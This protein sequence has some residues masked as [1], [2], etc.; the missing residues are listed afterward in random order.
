MYIVFTK[1]GERKPNVAKWTSPS[2]FCE[3]HGVISAA[4]A[5]K[6]KAAWGRYK[7]QYLY[8]CPKCAS[9]VEPGWLPAESVIDFSNKGERIGDKKKPLSAKTERRGRG[10]IEKFWRPIV[11]E[12]AGNTYDSADPKHPQHGDQNGYLRAWP[13]DDPLRTLHATASK[14]M[15]VPPLIT[16]RIHGVDQVTSS[17]DPMFTQTTAQTKSVLF[18]PILIPVEGR[19]G[20][21]A[22]SS[23]EPLRTQTTRHQDAIIIPF[24][25]NNVAKPVSEPLDTVRA[26]GNHHGLLVPA[27][28]TWRDEATS[29]AEP[30]P[31]RTTVETDALLVPYYGNGT[32][33][34]TSEAHRTLTTTD[35][36]ALL[37][38][39]EMSIEWEDCFFR[40]L[41]PDE[42]KQGMAFAADYLILGNK[43]EQVKQAGNAVTPPAARDLGM[44]VAEA[45]NGVELTRAT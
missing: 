24:T 26:G 41:T 9:I 38:A 33:A 8:R 4:Q 17:A 43:R 44:A 30:M 25:T 3:T 23:S 35:R 39:G 32:A 27:G 40:M 19:E 20:K 42:I 34:P 13:I 15:V 10:G 14:A 16:D 6:K 5:M 29:L 21:E 18:P 7:A 28:G 12:A 2:A 1:K 37:E 31:A 36:Y 11:M 45:L 22:A